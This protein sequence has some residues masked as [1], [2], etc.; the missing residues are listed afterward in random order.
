M[1]HQRTWI[2]VADAS[3]AR[4]FEKPPKHDHIDGPPK[5]TLI[6][7]PLRSSDIRSDRAGRTFDR[8]GFGRHAKEPVTDPSRVKKSR[9]AHAIAEK[10][11][12]ERKREAFNRLILVA[13]PRFLGD[14][15]KNLAEPVR[16]L[17]VAEIAK[18]LAS[19]PTS[20]IDDRLGI[21]L[22]PYEH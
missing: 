13:P 12:S 9:F 16:K 20:E 2:L 10:L 1:A 6:G 14:L 11:D 21:V 15:R 18:D 4:I 22:R 5:Y 7:T 3:V 19:L 17:M 8:V